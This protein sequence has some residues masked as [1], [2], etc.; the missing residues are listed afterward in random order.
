MLSTAQPGDG[1]P[2]ITFLSF[3]GVFLILIKKFRQG[4]SGKLSTGASTE[5]PRSEQ[6]LLDLQDD[7]S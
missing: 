7:A 4:N 3:L 2:G 6:L 1:L 5:V